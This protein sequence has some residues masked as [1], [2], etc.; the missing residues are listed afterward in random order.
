MD[1]G[2]ASYTSRKCVTGTNSVPPHLQFLNYPDSSM[3][4]SFPNTP[5]DSGENSASSGT[6][7]ADADEAA[8]LRKPATV[9]KLLLSPAAVKRRLHGGNSR[10]PSPAKVTF[11]LALWWDG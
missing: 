10:S 3:M 7:I 2:I 9:S 4:S 6:S 1:I 5:R 11:S 8:M